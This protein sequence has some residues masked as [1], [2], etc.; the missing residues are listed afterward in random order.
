[1]CT[2]LERILAKDVYDVCITDKL[3]SIHQ[4]QCEPYTPL[5]PVSICD[6]RGEASPGL[7]CDDK[8][9][10]EGNDDESG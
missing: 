7:D 6:D 8:T 4:P 9:H 3:V 1:M 2:V 5:S 10:G